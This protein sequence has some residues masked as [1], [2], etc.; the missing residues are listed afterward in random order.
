M[1]ADAPTHERR[2]MTDAALIE[3]WTIWALTVDGYV[4]LHDEIDDEQTAKR[5][6]GAEQR[7][8]KDG[9]YA[10]EVYS[11]HMTSARWHESETTFPP[12]IDALIAS[13][14]DRARAMRT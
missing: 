5:M 11:I 9:R 14:A 4:K 1:D 3:Q 10:P 12:K 13:L 6:L 2:I 7:L 8:L